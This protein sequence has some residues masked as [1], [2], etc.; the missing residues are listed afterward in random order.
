[1]VTSL[2]SVALIK[3]SIRAQDS[4][5]RL[6][7]RTSA[8]SQFIAGLFRA[9]RVV[10]VG[11]RM[12]GWRPVRL[13]TTGCCGEVLGLEHVYIAKE[14]FPLGGKGGSGAQA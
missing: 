6:W 11:N 13:S 4:F 1:M 10:Q 8:V 2:G 9:Y 7:G 5:L 14:R 12:K 3:R